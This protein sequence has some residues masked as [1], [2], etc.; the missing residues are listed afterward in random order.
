MSA[1]ASWA[2]SVTSPPSVL[3]IVPA[4]VACVV[5]VRW[6]RAILPAAASS[7]SVSDSTSRSAAETRVAVTD[8]SAS[9][10]VTVLTTLPTMVES[11]EASTVPVLCAETRAP[12]S[13][14]RASPLRGAALTYACVSREMFVAASRRPNSRKMAITFGLMAP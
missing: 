12:A 9:S 2:V 13:A 8:A 6:L 10:F 7:E 11:M 3:T 5:P 4:M 14:A 1:V